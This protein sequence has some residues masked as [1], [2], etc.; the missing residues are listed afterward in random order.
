[1]AK[2]NEKKAVEERESRKEILRKRKH[3]EQMRQVRI[4]VFGVVGLLIL[5]IVIGLVN[6]LVIIP[7]RPVAEVNGEAITLRDWQK[8][9][10][11][12]RAQ[13][14]IFLE[15]QYDAFG[16]NV[17]II[18]QFAGQ[19]INEL[20]DSEALAQNTLDLM[21]QEQ[22]VRQAAEARGITVTD[23]D[24]DE[25]IGELF[26]YYGGGLPTPVPTA[27]EAP[28]PTPSLTPIPTPVIT[29]V[30][31]TAVPLP[32]E[33]AGPTATPRPTSTP[34]TEEAYN[35]LIG[36]LIGSFKD[37]GVD[38]A[39]YHEVVRTQIYYERLADA[40]AEEN[41]ILTEAEHAS[42][43]LLGFDTEADAN[44]AL[45]MMAEAEDGYLT[46]WNIVKSTPAD[47]EAPA[48][49]GASANENLWRTQTDLGDLYGT[50]VADAAF[51]LPIG[52][53]SDVIV[54][55]DIDPARYYLIQVSGREV[56]ELP[57]TTLDQEKNQL[58]SDLIDAQMESGVQLM[59]NWRNRIPT[60]PL[61]DPKF[62]AQPTA[63][64]ATLPAESG[65]DGT[66]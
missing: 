7:N 61:L 12:E 63:V 35:D 2:K 30:V 24:V 55:D 42:V 58:V 50:A 9:V 26:G 4:G 60:Q 43:Y 31:P 6:E 47:A 14:I 56:R 10:R 45:A 40:L 25:T 34:V 19:T 51:S 65:S 11:Y 29:D 20:L 57:Q 59:E 52:E 66:Q 53:T 38:E 27:T 41:G 28:V 62:L 54:R 36:E 8:R 37:Y 1:M 22:I 49:P 32:T 23:A 16:G 15:N 5:V 17:G 13:R 21:V 3:E 46:V 44:E 18:Q 33:T 64:P 48:F 39:T